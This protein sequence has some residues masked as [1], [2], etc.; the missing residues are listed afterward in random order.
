MKICFK[1]SIEKPLDE[2]YRHVR[3][4][5]GHLNK[6]IECTK[7]DTRT[8]YTKEHERILA[9]DRLRAMLPHRVE[10]RKLYVKKNP[11]VIQ[12]HK[13][14][15]AEKHPDRRSASNAVSNAIRDGKL[16]KLPC[17][18]CGKNAQGHHPDYSRPLDVVWLCPKH[19]KETH[20]LVKH[21]PC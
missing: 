17:F 3:M 10:A 18:V 2:F 14:R 21:A 5:D 4:K 11:K 7:R 12:S 16:E 20:A 8:R 15:W 6:C 1:C 13:K 9:Y 19:H